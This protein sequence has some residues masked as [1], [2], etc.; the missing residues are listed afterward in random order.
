M[1]IDVGISVGNAV[2]NAVMDRSGAGAGA[3]ARVNG[4]W[5][6]AAALCL[7][8]GALASCGTDRAPAY[9]GGRFGEVTH[10]GATHEE[11]VPEDEVRGRQLAVEGMRLLKDADSVR[12][13]VDMATARGRQKVSLHMD[14]HSNCTGTFD[15]GPTQRGDLIMIAGDA[16]YV[17]FTDASL[18][19]IRDSGALKGPETA[20]RVRERTDMARG[21][22]LKIPTGSGAPGASM[23]VNNCDLDRFTGQLQAEPEDGESFKALPETRRY[24]K[25][26]IPVV[27]SEDRQETT[28]Y[29]AAEGTPYVLAVRVEEDGGL[30]RDGARTMTMRMS[31]FDEPVDAVAPV[32]SRTID[33]SRISPDGP[34]GG[35]LFEV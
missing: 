34:G 4:R 17:R 20:A 7:A 35:S 12:I 5:V 2:R 22:Y 25:R 15:A 10:Q 24:G 19:A 1:G 33:I 30:G 13:G 14:R 21:K 18:D 3:R 28:L 32:A 31:A 8:V 27:E 6:R 9:S 29:V 11:S 16:T 26:V 23:P